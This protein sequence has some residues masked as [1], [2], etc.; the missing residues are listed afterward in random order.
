M[1]TAW[2]L[3]LFGFLEGW[4]VG[5]TGIGTGIIMTPV[6]ILVFHLPPAEAI[7]ISLIYSAFT[8]SA[9]AV[10]HLRQHTVDI[11]VLKRLFGGGLPGVLLG[12]GVISWS[13]HWDTQQIQQVLQYAIGITLMLVAL[14]FLI[15]KALRVQPSRDRPIPLPWIT[16]IAFLLGAILGF[17]SIGGGS[18]FMSFLGVTSRLSAQRLVGTIVTLGAGLTTVA[19]IVYAFAV[20]VPWSV[21]LWLSIGALP[22]VYL[23]SLW[24][25]RIP[26]RMLY[27]ALSV[28]LFFAGVKLM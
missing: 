3:I 5:M 18:L 26:E 13:R 23:G 14:N 12:S 22:G 17:T 8:K 15:Q 1:T 7:A 25:L 9:G 20:P 19:A 10:Q 28:L 4:L 27:G 16:G 11:P 2:G 21:L 24:T 6:L